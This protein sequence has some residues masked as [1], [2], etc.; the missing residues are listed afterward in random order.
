MYY[1]VALIVYVCALLLPW[2]ISETV[3]EQF[4]YREQLLGFGEFVRGDLP[5]FAIVLVLAGIALG[6]LTEVYEGAWIGGLQTSIEEGFGK[7]ALALQVGVGD[8]QTQTILAW[9]ATAQNKSDHKGIGL[10]ALKS[11]YG[12]HTD[13]GNGY[14]D[15]VVKHLLDKSA[16][17]TAV[18][19]SDLVSTVT[20]RMPPPTLSIPGILVWDET[21]SFYL[22]SPK[23]GVE[24]AIHFVTS[25]R[26][27][28]DKL[29]GVINHCKVSIEVAN[30][31][32]FNFQKWLNYFADQALKKDSTFNKDGTIVTFDGVWFKIQFDKTVVLKEKKTYVVIQER[33]YILEDERSYNISMRCPTYNMTFTLN[34]DNSL[35]NWSIKEPTVS[36]CEMHEEAQPLAII[37]RPDPSKISVRVPEWTLP[38]IAIAVEW[39]SPTALAGQRH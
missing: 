33:S 22:N 25:V 30:E 28:E 8:I 6:I 9:L 13:S 21:K 39:T 20:L 32:I 10:A 31:E 15:F 14:I 27:S 24:F 29:A 7:L 35:M 34:L 38:G 16:I 36:A 5:N 4:K 2:L 17:E 1:I 12:K 26:A 37:S 11:F 23:I 18:T 3:P 19:R